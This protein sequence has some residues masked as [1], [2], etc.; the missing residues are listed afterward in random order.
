MPGV[1]TA[2]LGLEDSN[3]ILIGLNGKV[4]VWNWLHLYGQMAMDN[5]KAGGTAYQAGLRML[6]LGLENFHLQAEYNYA[7]ERTYRYDNWL[8]SYT[9]M[10]QSIAHPLGTY[11]EEIIGVANYRW[12][13]FY[14]QFKYHH[15]TH[16]NLQN[17]NVLLS[18]EPEPQATLFSIN[19]IYDLQLGWFLTP[20]T[21]ANLSVGWM[22]RNHSIGLI[23]Q[24][25]DWLYFTLR[26]SLVNKYYDF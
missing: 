10:N 21:N 12:R 13:R 19:N 18:Y 11:F 6:H 23:S 16:E 20:K 14:G 26:T 7:P 9:H 8:Q 1:N 24:N 5:T 22:H 17:G 2:L 25:T 3:N 15:Q 4:K